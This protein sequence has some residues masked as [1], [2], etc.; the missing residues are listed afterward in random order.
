MRIDHRLTAGLIG[1][2][3]AFWQA[4]TGAAEPDVRTLAYEVAALQALHDLELDKDQLQSLAKLAEGTAGTL[5]S[6][7]NAPAPTAAFRTALTQLH[8]ALVKGKDTRI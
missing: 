4:P 5:K 3:V 2:V 7:K 1:L 8:E 6:Q